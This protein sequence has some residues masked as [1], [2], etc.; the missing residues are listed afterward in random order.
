MRKNINIREATPNN[1]NVCTGRESAE[2]L[3]K[4][5][6]SKDEAAAWHHDLKTARKALKFTADQ[7]Q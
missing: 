1:M 7:W 6:L 3:A 2:A 4:V 5:E